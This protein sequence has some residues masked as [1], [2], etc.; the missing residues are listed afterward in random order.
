MLLLSNL[1]IDEKGAHQLLQ[2]D[3]PEIQGVQLIHLMAYYQS[4]NPDIYKSFL[5]FSNILTNLT[6][7]PMIRKNIIDSE[8]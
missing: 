3:H 2:M 5:Y 1:L 8:V 4:D 6:Q 7:F